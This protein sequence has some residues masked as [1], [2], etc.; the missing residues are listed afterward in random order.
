MTV[1]SNAGASQ[2]TVSIVGFR[3]EYL[4]AFARLNRAWLEENGLLEHGDLKHLEHPR[5]SIL[6]TGGEIFFAV[7]GGEVVGTCGVIVE[8]AE[9]AE[10]VKLTVA[11]RLRG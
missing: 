3:P 2:P 7:E 1:E 10:L 9:T 4:D 6:A 11:R 5:E 8:D